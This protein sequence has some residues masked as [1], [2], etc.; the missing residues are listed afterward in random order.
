MKK[1]GWDCVGGDAHVLTG[2]KR[3]LKDELREW[4]TLHW[5]TLDLNEFERR[6][7][8]VEDTLEARSKGE[9]PKSPGHKKFRCYTCNKEGHTSPYCPTTKQNWTE[10]AKPKTGVRAGTVVWSDDDMIR[11]DLT[12]AGRTY[13]GLVDTGCTYC[14]IRKEI[15]EELGIPITEG[16]PRVVRL[17]NNEELVV[18]K[19]CNIEF[20]MD[21]ERFL[22][23]FYIFETDMSSDIHL[24][25]TFAK[26]N[27]LVNCSQSDVPINRLQ[28]KYGV[29]EE[30]E[31]GELSV[32][33]AIDTV[34]GSKVFRQDY[35]YDYEMEKQIEEEVKRQMKLGY[36]EY[37][38][39]EWLNPIRPVTKRDGTLRLCLDL[40]FLNKLVKKN[41]YWQPWINDILEG[42]KGQR[43]I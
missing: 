10:S 6:M 33:C 13:R 4:A 34:E 42:L 17:A 24:G 37:C 19:W 2:I 15:V 21:D 27:K 8:R 1:L 32:E 11:K 26:R 31:G 14:D 20:I 12:I 16:A 38:T 25:V 22:D 3:G 5:E 30:G 36:I 9:N 7:N 40:R 39:S 41:Q 35:R 18:T 43:Y 29:F 28:G 23:I